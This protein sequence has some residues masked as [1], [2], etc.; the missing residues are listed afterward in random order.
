MIGYAA[1]IAMRIIDGATIMIARRRSGIP[2]ER[3]RGCVAPACCTE[4]ASMALEGRQ[5]AVDLVAGLLDRVRRT[6]PTRKSVVDVLVDRLR[7][8]RIHRRDRPRLRRA[9]GL[10]EL[11]G[12]RNGLLHARVV[13]RGVE[14]RRRGVLREREPLSS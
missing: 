13:V 9:E 10:L 12:V 2:L 7:D 14:D 3:R 8:L 11:G 6:R 4:A 1:T 5:R